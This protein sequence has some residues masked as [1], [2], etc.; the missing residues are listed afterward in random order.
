[1]NIRPVVWLWAIAG[2]LFVWIT[3]LFAA[4]TIVKGLA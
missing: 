3:L 2:C 4:E 1:M